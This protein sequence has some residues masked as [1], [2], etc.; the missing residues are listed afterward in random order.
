MRPRLVLALITGWAS[1]VV[2][3]SGEDTLLIARVEHGLRSPVTVD[4]R[5][6]VHFTLLDRMAA[7]RV[8]G[9]SIAVLDSGRIVWARG[10]GVRDAGGTDPVTSE[11]LFQAASISKPVATIGMLRL[12][13]RGLLD[14]DRDINGYLQSWQVPE[15]RFTRPGIVTLRRLVSHSAGLTIHGFPGYPVGADLPTLPQ[16]LS[17]LRPAN[18]GPVVVDTLPGTVWR[19]S[20]GGI[21]VMQLAMTEVTGLPFDRLMRELVL[22]PFGMSGSSYS[23]PLEP[24]RAVR[25]A[26]GHRRDGSVIPGKWHVY[27]E[28][29]AAGLWTTPS[30]LARVALTVW[31]LDRG[32]SDLLSPDLTRQMLSIQNA[33]SGLGFMLE[34]DGD[35]LRFHHGGSNNGF[36]ATFVAS[37][38]R[39]QGA[40]I[41]TNGDQGE[42]LAAELLQAVAL[43]YRWPWLGPR[44]VRPARLR[45]TLLE[46]T[47]GR[48]RVMG[49]SDVVAD[50][51]LADGR[52]YFEVAGTVDRTE[53]V[54]LDDQRF[55]ALDLGWEVTVERQGKNGR[56]TAIIVM[57]TRAIRIE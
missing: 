30:D 47:A 1:A 11:T 3:Q 19:Y 14:L 29:A 35:D 44:V 16:I 20:G 8:P 51:T 57:G 25:A 28:Q 45:R 27:P 40:V 42:Q 10:Y 31:R 49:T 36:R 50:I 39:G 52:L 53:L 38:H 17:G 7:L 13:D 55:V 43:E 12:V 34:Q 33:P 41:M 37:R 56:G 2:A 23:Q 18:T 4:G 6:A 5:P 48:Y 9:V 26:S 21:T 15:N 32:E 24:A 46:G 54:P 22:D